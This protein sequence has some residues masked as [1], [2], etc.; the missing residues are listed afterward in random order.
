MKKLI[1]TLMIVLLIAMTSC[2]TV[3]KEKPVFKYI[4]SKVVSSELADDGCYAV[5]LLLETGDEYSF[6]SDEDLSKITEKIDINMGYDMNEKA[7]MQAC[8]EPQN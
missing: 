3:K 4:N 2:E 5:T 6:H 1:S 7:S 8:I